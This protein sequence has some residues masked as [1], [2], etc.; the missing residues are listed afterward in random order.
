MAAASPA[1]R[2]GTVAHDDDERQIREDLAAARREHR[3]LDAS[4][5]ELSASGTDPIRIQR[6]KK[7]KLALKD[8]IAALEDRLFPDIIA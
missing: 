2:E 5:A 7:R 3:E 1:P 4:I 6:L 8:Q